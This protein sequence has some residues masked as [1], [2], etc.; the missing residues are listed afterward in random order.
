MSW[1]ETA[2]IIAQPDVKAGFGENKRKT[3][4]VSA[5]ESTSRLQQTMHEKDWIFSFPI[6]VLAPGRTFDL[7]IAQGFL[8]EHTC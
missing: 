7:A 8:T 6:F 5:T 2:T 4:I 1:L 3:V